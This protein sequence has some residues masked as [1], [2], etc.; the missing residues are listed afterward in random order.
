MVLPD[1][2]TSDASAA[3]SDHRE[4]REMLHDRSVHSSACRLSPASPRPSSRSR[5]AAQQLNLYTTREPGLIQPLLDAFTKATG[6]KV[7]TIFV[8]DGLAERV[9]PKARARRPTC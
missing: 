9:P 4:F 7:N 6:I 2:M 5:G 8:R 1:V 3:G